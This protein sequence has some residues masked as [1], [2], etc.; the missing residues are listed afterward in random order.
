MRRGSGNR[1][2]RSGFLG[3]ATMVGGARTCRPEAQARSSETH[4]PGVDGTLDR[5][6]DREHADG[7]RFEVGGVSAGGPGSERTQPCWT[8]GFMT[9]VR[10]PFVVPTSSARSAAFVRSRP[11]LR[12]RRARM[13]R[14]DRRVTSSRIVRDYSIP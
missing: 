1:V 9:W 11:S 3:R 2:P 10:N 5:L 12:A 4:R 14:S 8:R 13:A 7:G 6:D